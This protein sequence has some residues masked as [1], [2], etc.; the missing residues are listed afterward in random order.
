MNQIEP[1]NLTQASWDERISVLC[2]Q[3]FVHIPG[4][5]APP[6]L[7]RVQAAVETAF[8]DA[9]FG[10]N[11]QS[12]AAE[13]E[14]RLVGLGEDVDILPV[15]QLRNESLCAMLLDPALLSALQGLLGKDYYLDR[16]VV[17]RA[18]GRCNRFYFHKDQH[19]D[20]GLTVLLN[21]LGR[22]EGATTVIPG[23]FLGT[24]PSV[25]AIKHINA[26]HPNEV[27]M[28][29]AA[30]DA[31][32]F[33]RDIDHSRAPNLTDK[34]NVQLIFTFVNRN[35]FPAAHSRQNI[36]PD[37][38]E[39]LA[40]TLRHMLRPYDGIPLDRPRGLIEKVIYGSGF[41]SPGAGDYDARNDVFRDFFYTMFYVKGTPLR[42]NPDDDL[43]RNTTIMNERMR[44]TM[45]QFAARL[46]WW[47]LTRA[48]I[49]KFLRGFAAGRSLIDVLRRLR[50]TLAK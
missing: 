6:L 15:V 21:D 8:A 20:I 11:E 50:S 29:G 7:G 31:Y 22:D 35:T 48:M 1:T 18:R 33:F 34:S 5:V 13:D 30:G 38:L 17:R 23:R 19:G 47:L 41:T 12:G 10:R 16:S 28:T 2:R 40:P 25:F 3:G 44:V 42:T 4:F 26:A 45:S 49:L 46:N 37:D 24:P 39:G 9:P 36:G 27:Q 43:P 32:L 14:S